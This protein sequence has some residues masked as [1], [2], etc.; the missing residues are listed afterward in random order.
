MATT[1]ERLEAQVD[2]DVA[3]AIAGLEALNAVITM[4]TKNHRGK[5]DLDTRGSVRAAAGLKAALGGLL[6]SLKFLPSTIAAGE[7]ALSGMKTAL[8]EVGSNLQHLG[9]QAV[10]QLSTSLKGM[11]GSWQQ[12]AGTMALYFAAVP[13]VAGVINALIGGVTALA[14]A[15]VGP[16]VGA[17]T[18]GV[19]ALGAFVAGAVVLFAALKPVISAVSL[20]Q[21]ATAAS[22]KAN[23]AGGTAARDRAAAE[24]SLALAQREVVAAQKE[25]AAAEKDLAA[26]RVRAAEHLEDVERSYT[27]AVLDEE[28]AVLNLKKAQERLANAQGK[29]ADASIKTTKL[30][31]DFT[32]KVYEVGIA[33]ESATDNADNLAQA[34]LDVKQAELALATA[35]DHTQDSRNALIEAQRKGI[36][37]SDEV[38][39]ANERMQRAQERLSDA[40]YALQQAQKSLR[41]KGIGTAAINAWDAYNKAMSK[42]PPK[43]QDA[44]RLI[45]GTFIPAFKKMQSNI[46][47]NFAPG[48]LAGLQNLTKMIPIVDYWAGRFAATLGGLFEYFT[49]KF[50]TPEAL[51]D[52]STIFSGLNTV[53]GNVGAALASLGRTFQIILAEATPFTDWLSE[54]LKKS[55]DDLEK[56][57]TDNRKGIG[58][59]F[60][61]LKPRIKTVWGI[62][63]NLTSTIANLFRTASPA[64]QSMLKSLEGITKKW[65]DWT[66]KPENQAKMKDFF[67]KA[68][69][70]FKDI[71]QF[72][73][74]IAA[75]IVKFEIPPGFAG[76][77]TDVKDI[78][79]DLKPL[80]T[81]L[82]V[83]AVLGI[84][85]LKATVDT[86]VF[87]FNWLGTKLG[88]WAY[89]L[90]TKIPQAWD[91]TKRKFSDGISYIKNHVPDFGAW[92]GGFKT[93]LSEGWDWVQRKF[94]EFTGWFKYHKPDFGGFWDGLKN[95][96]KAVMNYIIKKW[97]D[98]D[99]SLQLPAI[100]GGG[101]VGIGTP[102][103]DPWRERGGRVKAHQPYIVGEKRAEVFV[104]DTPGRIKPRVPSRFMGGDSSGGGLTK[105]DLAMLLKGLPQAKQVK[106]DQTFNEKVDPKLLSAELAWKL[107]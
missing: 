2:A 88:E 81:F 17:L 74:D 69:K 86:L 82:G 49:A 57:V 107:G 76:A 87:P 31:D 84:K 23:T 59:W 102:N 19:A 20:F 11:A 44:V 77:L 42:L 51:K 66:G 52:M 67:D 3:K 63:K 35:Q 98:L 39:A 100:L 53:L 34:Q 64:G 89:W 18:F 55:F 97:N 30:T 22:N 99:L 94:G 68:V 104:P 80:F 40:T 26:A 54:E 10:D 92:W 9:G 37:Q 91:A 12:A 58:A 33:A 6:D 46:S 72:V 32:G 25:A 48:F 93:K 60:E 14:A 90:S 105:K 83:G 65:S 41:T 50:T 1:V 15:L 101:K 36:A 38:V 75:Y 13:L 73:S 47:A 95:A 71:S 8:G 5:V 29:I 62:I 85:A 7:S 21:K 56:K 78:L 16:L 96:F 61:K 4:V 45:T 70:A 79:D 103:I 24:H 27:G 43:M 106:I 28:Q